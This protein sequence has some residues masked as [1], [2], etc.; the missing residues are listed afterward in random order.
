[1]AAGRVEMPSLPAV[2]GDDCVAAPETESVAAPTPPS[3]FSASLAAGSLEVCAESFGEAM[4]PTA[5]NSASRPTTTAGM[6]SLRLGLR[7]MASLLFG[8]GA[9]GR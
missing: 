4:I 6:R 9:S 3:P 7:I 5:T 8:P 1:M 2:P